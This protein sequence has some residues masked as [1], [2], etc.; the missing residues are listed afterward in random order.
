MPK[1]TLDKTKK[2]ESLIR[3]YVLGTMRAN[4]I[5]QSDM[6]SE[7]GITQQAFSRKIKNGSLTVADLL[8]IFERLQP[9]DSTLLK[10][11]RGMK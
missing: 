3:A 10:L 9:D 1:V 5:S 4:D 6:A 8:R 7:L 2:T 11:M